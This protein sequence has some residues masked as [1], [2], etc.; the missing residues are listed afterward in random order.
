[1]LSRFWELVLNMVN[2]FI[3]ANSYFKL[4]ILCVFLLHVF[5]SVITVMRCVFNLGPPGD[6]CTDIAYTL[7][8]KCGKC[9][10]VTVTKHLVMKSLMGIGRWINT[11]LQ[12]SQLQHVSEPFR[13]RS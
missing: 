13:P 6:K 2:R 9:N 7:A 4:W 3:A 5:V 12:T 1:M 8:Q 10:V 11:W